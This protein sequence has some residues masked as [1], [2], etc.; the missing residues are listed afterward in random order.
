M[1]VDTYNMLNLTANDLIGQ[2]VAVLGIKGS[3]KSNTAAVLMEEL[4]QAG[5]PICVVDIA[6]EYY[7]LRDEF[8]QVT[9]IGNSITTEVQIQLTASNVVDVAEKA[10]LSASSVILDLSKMGRDPRLELLLAYFS[11][12]WQ[13]A[14]FHRYPLVIFLEE[15]HNW[16]PQVGKTPLTDR[17]I[18]IATEGRKR[19]LSLVMVG[20]RSSKIHKDTLTQADIAF[21]HRVRHPVD[22]NV[23]YGLVP[24]KK[25]K[26]QDMVNKLRVG[27]AL[28][29]MGDKVIRCT[30]RKRRTRHIG[31]TP[32]L[33]QLPAQQLSL[34]DMLGKE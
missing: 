9:V 12:I 8:P 23:Y 3:G 33:S 26:V 30:I 10:Y 21:L 25:P 2:S 28:V 11:R 32:D 27:D 17:L 7:S 18:D 31:F 6:G 20:T 29:L 34:L 13:L 16:I 19:G 1:N 15:A 14:A 22:M 24:R 5:A 4:L